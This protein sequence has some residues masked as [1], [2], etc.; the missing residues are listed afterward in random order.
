VLV[1]SQLSISCAEVKQILGEAGSEAEVV[2]DVLSVFCFWGLGTKTGHS[3]AAH[4]GEVAKTRHRICSSRT[5][6]PNKTKTKQ[7][8]NKNKTKTKQKQN[9]NK[10][11]TKQNKTKQNKNKT[12]TKTYA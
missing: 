5:P 2:H 12:K 11:K 4:E 6:S 9:K 10:T 3:I 8:Q 7:K 1:A